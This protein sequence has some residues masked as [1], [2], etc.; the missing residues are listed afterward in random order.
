MASID[1]QILLKLGPEDAAA[2]ARIAEVEHV[3]IEAAATRLL[4]DALDHSSIAT[5]MVEDLIDTTPGLY[6]R[7]RE[8]RAQGRA[9][10]TIPL[11][12]LRQ[13]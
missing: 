10:R 12:E 1:T 5:A 13:T 9:G 7:L 11:S 8:S 6:E 2:L 4:H 3:T